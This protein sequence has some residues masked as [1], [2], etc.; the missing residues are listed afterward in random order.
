MRI[1]L[2]VGGTAF[3]L[4]LAAGSAW[5]A[6][7]MRDAAEQSELLGVPDLP[8]RLVVTLA[9]LVIALLYARRIVSELAGR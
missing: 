8:L 6:W 3:F 9:T 2:A 7:D 1:L 5:I 4:A